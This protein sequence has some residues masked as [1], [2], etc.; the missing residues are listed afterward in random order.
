LLLPRQRA[1]KVGFLTTGS[2]LKR[3]GE[4]HRPW[5]RRFGRG[6]GCMA[7][8]VCGASPPL[9]VWPERLM[10][11]IMPTGVLPAA[12][13]AVDYLLTW[14]CKHLANAQVARRITVVCEDL[15]HR[16]PIICTPEELMGA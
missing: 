8:W 15:G 13:H 12:V 11:A 14:N 1:K 3:C 6:A 4:R 2:L 7:D 10:Q 9:R 5:W 16:I